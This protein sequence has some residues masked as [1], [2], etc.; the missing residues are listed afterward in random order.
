MLPLKKKYI[1]VYINVYIYII[2]LYKIFKFVYIFIFI[3]N[4]CQK[5][6]TQSRFQVMLWSH[7]FG[8]ITAMNGEL[9]KI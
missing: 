2:L 6:T 9:Q 1:Y 4:S 5:I 7:A 8:T 3:L